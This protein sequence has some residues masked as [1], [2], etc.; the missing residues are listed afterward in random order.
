[1]VQVL[2]QETLDELVKETPLG[3]LGTPE[4]IAYAVAFFA[5]ERAGFIT[6]HVLTADGRL[7]RLTNTETMKR[8]TAAERQS[9]M[10]SIGSEM[11]SGSPISASNAFQLPHRQPHLYR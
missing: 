2:G 11:L 10:L 3:R 8:G 1:M 5:S 6:G 9:L 4:D 7:H